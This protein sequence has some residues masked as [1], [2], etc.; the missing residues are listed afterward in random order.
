VYELTHFFHC[1]RLSS[2]SDQKCERTECLNN[3]KELES[4]KQQIRQRQQEHTQELQRATQEVERKQQECNQAR[5]ELERVK[6]DIER[7]QSQPCQSRLCQNAQLALLNTR[8]GPPITGDDDSEIPLTTFLEKLYN[9][10]EENQKILQQEN[11]ELELR[12]ELDR[13]RSKI[14]A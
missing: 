4:L 3:E 12:N 1:G 13:A 6:Q 5:Q 11:Q 10:I 14:A 2:K 9:K 8:I 7:I